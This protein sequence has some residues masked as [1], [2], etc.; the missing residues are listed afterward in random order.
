MY[1]K[2][3]HQSFAS[4]S[5][6]EDL[7]ISTIVECIYNKLNNFFNIFNELEGSDRDLRVNMQRRCCKYITSMDIYV[8][9]Q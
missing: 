8:K 1:S 2:G 5:D 6:Q 3:A 7:L 4:H 9:L